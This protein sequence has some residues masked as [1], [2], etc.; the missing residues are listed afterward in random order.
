[1]AKRTNNKEAKP[2]MVEKPIQIDWDSLGVN[3]NVIGVSGRHLTVGKEYTIS[4]E[5][6]KILVNKGVARLK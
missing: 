6:A 2:V 4:K 3:V 1:M 5:T